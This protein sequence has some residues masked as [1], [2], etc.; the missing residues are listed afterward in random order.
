MTIPFVKHAVNCIISLCIL[1]LLLTGCTTVKPD[2][3]KPP[4]IP[5][6]SAF[7][8][9]FS[10]FTNQ[11]AALSPEGQTASLVT[12]TPFSSSRSY[13]NNALGDRG[14]WL[15]AALNVGFW[16]IMGVL[17][18]A[19]P[20]ASFVESFKHTPVQQSDGSWVW[21]YNVPVGGTTYN[22]ALHGKYVN[23]GVRWEM[24][25]TKQ[26]EYSDFLWYYGE[27]DLP[28]TSGFWVLKDKPF[29]PTDLLRIDW[30]RNL[31]NNTGDIKYTNIIPGGAENG[32]FISFTVSES[33]EF[34]RAYQIFNK[35]K[36]ETTY[37]EWNHV[38]LEG[39]VKDSIHFGNNDWHCWD[40]QLINTDCR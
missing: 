35:G 18:L 6:E 4:Q 40:S 17:G 5:P 20:V 21:T 27:S 2:Y 30:H 16:N 37:I 22:A 39:R 33:I 29:V 3:S 14:N 28:V 13:I 8:M 7:V 34:D 24:Y 38:T 15:F 11:Q 1:T 26:G 23:Q 31:E 32:G 36:N 12:F 10:N 9:D 19:V 25:V